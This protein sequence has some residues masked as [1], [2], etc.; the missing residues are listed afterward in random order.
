[1]EEIRWF[2]YKLGLVTIMSRHMLLLIY[3]GQGMVSID[4]SPASFCKLSIYQSKSC[5]YILN[6][7]LA[8]MTKLQVVLKPYTLPIL[9][10]SYPLHPYLNPHKLL[11]QSL[12]VISSDIFPLFLIS[13]LN[14]CSH[15]ERSH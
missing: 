12:L 11:E 2:E 8:K 7:Y 1:M 14:P 6:L 15:F 3:S 4:I 9:N 5:N 13:H 10:T